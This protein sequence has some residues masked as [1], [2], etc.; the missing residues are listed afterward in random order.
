MFN[1]RRK[2]C[3]KPTYLRIHVQDVGSME[4][5][6]RYMEVVENS[7]GLEVLDE[8][9][10]QWIYLLITLQ[11]AFCTLTELLPLHNSGMLD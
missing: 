8:P 2:S 6:S 4:V 9:I 11:I 3:V 1:L 7:P 5:L 10:Q